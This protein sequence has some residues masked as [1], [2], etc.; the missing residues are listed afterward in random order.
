V[1]L[2]SKNTTEYSG[3]ESYVASLYDKGEIN[4]IPRTK[5]ICLSGLDEEDS[6]DAEV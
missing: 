6:D 1:H 2:Q 4:W 3:I 5:A